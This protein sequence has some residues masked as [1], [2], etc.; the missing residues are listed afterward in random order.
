ML[1]DAIA[2]KNATPTIDLKG[3]NIVENE[4]RQKVWERNDALPKK[5]PQKKSRKSV[6]KYTGDMI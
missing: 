5:S 4:E 3:Q 1:G 2:S 6:S